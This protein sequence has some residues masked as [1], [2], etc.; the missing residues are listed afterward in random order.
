MKGVVKSAIRIAVLA[1]IF[2][3]ALAPAGAQ[4]LAVELGRGLVC[5]TQRQV[6]RFVALFA[7]D[8]EA[9]VAAVNR[10]EN[11][12]TACVIATI[13]FVR[14]PA[15][16]TVRNRKAAYRIVRILV[17]GVLTETGL[18]AAIPEAFYSIDEVE[19]QDA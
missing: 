1:A 18:Q 4:G 11:D 9:A 12:P 19:E 5:D 7:G 13:A 10:E 6:E 15:I 17:V 16:G 8:A 2:L 14:G 3:F